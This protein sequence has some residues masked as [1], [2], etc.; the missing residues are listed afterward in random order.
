MQQHPDI[1]EKEDNMNGWI[2]PVCGSGVNPSV[3]VCPCS[4]PRTS[5]NAVGTVDPHIIKIDTNH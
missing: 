3:T 4:Q 5:I 1:S 2:C